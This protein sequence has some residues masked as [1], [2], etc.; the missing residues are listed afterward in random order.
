MDNTMLT[1]KPGVKPT[2]W[3]GQTGLSFP[4]TML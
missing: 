4:G 2:E 1:M 3:D